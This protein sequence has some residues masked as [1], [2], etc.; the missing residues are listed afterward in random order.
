MYGAQCPINVDDIAITGE[1]SGGIAQLKLVAEV[2]Y[3][4]F[5][6]TLIFFGD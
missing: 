5:G 6:K 3:K 2:S 1:D 4:G